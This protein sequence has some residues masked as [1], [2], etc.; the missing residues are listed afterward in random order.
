MAVAHR[1]GSQ[2]VWPGAFWLPGITPRVEIASHR[3]GRAH[4]AP[5]RGVVNECG[6]STE[7]TAR[8]SPVLP[9][10]PWRA[11]GRECGPWRKP[12]RVDGDSCLSCP[13]FLSGRFSATMLGRRGTRLNRFA[14]DGSATCAGLNLKPIRLSTCGRRHRL[15][16]ALYRGLV[17]PKQNRQR[18]FRPARRSRQ[19]GRNGNGVTMTPRFPKRQRGHDDPAIPETATGSR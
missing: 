3:H 17:V 6:C 1:K 2:V 13:H 10:R 14:R 16:G 5:K 11:A 15:L 7:M 8:S 12:G 9:P 18:T 4:P 19:D